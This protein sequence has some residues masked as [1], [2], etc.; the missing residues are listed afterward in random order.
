MRESG[1]QPMVGESGNNRSSQCSYVLSK[2]QLLVQDD[3]QGP[4]QR[5]RRQR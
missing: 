3:P 4:G 2:R 1:K 5:W